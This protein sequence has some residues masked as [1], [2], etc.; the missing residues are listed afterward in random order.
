MFWCSL[1]SE[2]G[3][4]PLGEDVLS[5]LGNTMSYNRNLK[6]FMGQSFR[7]VWKL[8]LKRVFDLRYKWKMP[9]WK[10][11]GIGGIFNVMGDSFD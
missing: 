4:R 6:E 7:L 3:L 5:L 9:S 11:K 1:Y 2:H 10:V 8:Q